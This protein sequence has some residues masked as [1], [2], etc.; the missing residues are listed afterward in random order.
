MVVKKTQTHQGTVS[1]TD[2]YLEHKAKRC[3]NTENKD[4]D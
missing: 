4:S 3:Q 1:Y 2:Y